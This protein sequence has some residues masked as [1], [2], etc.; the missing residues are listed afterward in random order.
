MKKYELLLFDADETLFDFHRAMRTALSR[1]LQ[2]FGIVSGDEII[3]IYDKINKDCWRRFEKGELT[4]EALQ[5]ERFVVFLSK[6]GADILPEKFNEAYLDNLSRC[7]FL[8]DGAKELC[9]DLSQYYRLAIITNGIPS[10]QRR[11]IAGSEIAQYFEYVLISGDT[12]YK[13]PDKEFFD[14]VF[15]FYKGLERDKALII[16]DSLSADIKGGNNAGVDTCWL[17]R[18]GLPRDPEIHVDYEVSSLEEIRKL[19]IKPE[20]ENAIGI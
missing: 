19:L 9:K 8:L 2:Q 16:G 6:I 17:N 5:K 11:R 20:D 7:P 4:R 18:L 1:A 13:K 14:Y 15:S 10:M 12:E 3:N